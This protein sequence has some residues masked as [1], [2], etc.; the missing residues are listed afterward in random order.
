MIVEFRILKLMG[1]GFREQIVELK[2]QGYKT[3]PAFGLLLNLADSYQ[4]LLELE[5]MSEDELKV[6]LLSRI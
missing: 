3:E 6:F 4:Q 5:R 1:V 2:K